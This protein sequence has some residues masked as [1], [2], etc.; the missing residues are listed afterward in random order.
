[1]PRLGGRQL[2]DELPDPQHVLPFHRVFQVR[3]SFQEE[4][5]IVRCNGERSLLTKKKKINLLF[6]VRLEKLAKSVAVAICRE[7]RERTDRHRIRI[8]SRE[9]EVDVLA[10]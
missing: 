4:E 2:P 5:E 9:N 10:V 1:V 6:P 3:R 8:Q 7:I